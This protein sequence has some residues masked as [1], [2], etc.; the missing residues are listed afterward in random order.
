MPEFGQHG[1]WL[2]K[3]SFVQVSQEV[4]G[5]RA[6]VLLQPR[7]FHWLCAPARH[8]QLQYQLCMSLFIFPCCTSP[9]ASQGTSTQ[10]DDFSPVE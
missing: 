9:A 5:E 8:C 6:G 3:P 10:S 1:R 2:W 7:C 4:Q